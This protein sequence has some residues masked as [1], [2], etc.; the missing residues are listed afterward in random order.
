MK[1]NKVDFILGIT[2]GD[3]FLVKIDLKLQPILICLL[4]PTQQ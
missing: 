4:I 2:K 3:I 1:T